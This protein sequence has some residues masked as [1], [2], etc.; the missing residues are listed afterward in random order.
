MRT[1]YKI[2][3][4][5]QKVIH[6]FTQLPIGGKNIVCPYFIN[7]K[8][9]R[10]GLRVLIGKGDPGEI[11]RE[12]NVHAQLK[13]LDIY[14]L[15]ETEIRQFMIDNHIGI[16]CSAL[17]VHILNYWLK[18]QGDSPLIKYLKFTNSSF[19][20]KLKRQL[21]PVEQ[22]GANLLTNH[23]NTSKV[24]NLNDV[25]PGDL[26]RSKGQRTNSHH[27]MLITEVTTHDGVVK[28]IEY[29]HSV[30]QYN[31]ENGV[32]FGKILVNNIHE[33]LHEQNWTELKDGRNWAYEGY[34]KN[35][36]DNGIRRLKNV[37]LKFNTETHE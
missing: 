6:E 15:N 28:E 37:K 17:V 20:S 25:R 30:K 26:I 8:S 22:I 10:A 31:E 2:P 3:E 24:K 32:R 19:I 1:I 27:V 7:P 18:N 35:L 5:A 21:R 34:I 9:Q 29:V 14:K 16:D 11:A 13:S 4:S 33:K 36:E 23:D 12:V